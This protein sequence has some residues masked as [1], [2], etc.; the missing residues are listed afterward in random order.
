MSSKLK[1]LTII[2]EILFENL[3][4]NFC[5]V[6]YTRPF[7]IDVQWNRLQAADCNE[8]QWISKPAKYQSGKNCQVVYCINHSKTMSSLDS[9]FWFWF[10]AEIFER[11][12]LHS[13][14]DLTTRFII[15]LFLAWNKFSVDSNFWLRSGFDFEVDSEFGW[16]PDSDGLNSPLCALIL[17]SRSFIRLID[18]SN[19][20]S[21]FAT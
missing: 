2:P 20:V 7:M 13:F 1:N 3:I 10:D 17:S 15:F 12:E 6:N 21:Y 11:K 19:S 4:F 5:S 9:F 16:D 14:L 18:T 8:W